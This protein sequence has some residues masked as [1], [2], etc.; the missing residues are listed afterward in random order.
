MTIWL[1]ESYPLLLQYVSLHNYVIELSC[2]H[3]III[4]ILL[5]YPLHEHIH[6]VI[7]EYWQHQLY[8]SYKP[9]V[10]QSV[11]T[12]WG[13]MFING[14]RECIKIYSN[15]FGYNHHDNTVSNNSRTVTN[16]IRNR[17]MKLVTVIILI[18]CLWIWCDTL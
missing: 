13:K 16:L 3:I 5:P 14:Y 12:K 9:N 6:N 7:S 1:N 18:H 4:H 8:H 11:Y 17:I 10:V 15:Q 2:D